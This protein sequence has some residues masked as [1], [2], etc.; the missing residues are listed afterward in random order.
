MVFDNKGRLTAKPVKD[1]KIKLIKIIG[2]T[3]LLKK[4]QLNLADGSN[5]LVDKDDYKTG[6]SVLIEL[7][8]KKI[9]EHFKLGPG[10]LAYITSGN[11]IGQ[12]GTIEKIEK[13]ETYVKS[14]EGTFKTLKAY[15][16]VIG[17][18]KPSVE[19]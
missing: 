16:F 4:T 11:H 18:E 7:D 15:I 13:N 9:K 8:S 3:R 6:D 2:K 17:K 1:D 19:L 12:M 10:M 5:I 14:K